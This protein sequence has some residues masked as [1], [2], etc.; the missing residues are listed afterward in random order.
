MIIKTIAFG[1]YDEAF[2]ETR[3]KNRVNVIFSND[4][5][6]GKTLI[7]QSLMYSIGNSPIF[8]S[9]F[10]DYN[11]YFYSEI[12][13]NNIDYKFLRRKDTIIVKYKGNME[14]Y[15]SISDFKQFFDKT[16]FKL[17]RY[18]SDG[19]VFVADLSMFYQLFFLPQD[20]RNTSN[21]INSGYLNKTDYILM[22]KSIIRGSLPDIDEKVIRE[23]KE[24]MK[25]IEREISKISKRNVY[26]KQHPEI[27]ER[28]L[29]SV[30]TQRY[31]ALEAEIR[32]INSRITN[33]SKQR[34]RE[35][36]RKIKLENLIEELNSLNRNIE[37]GKIKCGDCG[38]EK[39]VYTND[40]VAFEISNDVV[41]KQ[42]IDSIKRQI[43]SRTNLIADLGLELRDLQAFLGTKIEV[44]PIEVG[45]LIISK[46]DILNEVS[47]D[48]KI[49]ELTAQL[50]IRSDELKKLQ[51]TVSE[52]ESNVNDTIQKI[53]IK[54]RNI[55]KEIDNS[56]SVYIDE[57]FT[58]HNETYSGSEEQIFYYSKLLALNSMLKLPFYTEPRK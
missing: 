37:I 30:G 12:N 26:S 16:I 38:S 29:E 51:S 58:K 48:S 28:I 46:D 47:N 40:D 5:N 13:C 21:I 43:E 41:R 34:N 14:I 27:A 39:I 44:M 17:P 31:A 25:A 15:E 4:N 42:I 56:S 53:I 55:Y 8:P 2:I 1:N 3:L 6:K 54:M 11:Y 20:K 32:D 49:V 22:L 57:L 35:M 52:V 19:N 45:D 7:I 10:D 33:I 36:N 9:T 24:K 23:I 50:I 18:I